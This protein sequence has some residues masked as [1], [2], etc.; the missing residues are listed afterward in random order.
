MKGGSII[1]NNLQIRKYFGEKENEPCP[2]TDELVASGYKQR[3]GGYISY[4]K[5]CGVDDKTIS[6]WWH[7]IRS[8][9]D[10][11]PL[12]APFSKSIQCGELL[13]YM[14]EITG[15]FSNKELNDLKNLI[16]TR[17]IN[18]RRNG[19]R[20]IQNTV[21]DRIKNIIDNCN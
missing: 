10:R 12:D 2:I 16:V 5:K 20:I 11:S 6:Q 4:A 8:W 7:L 15:A 1:M 18:D 3:S 21:W 19:N 17:Y 14:A 9:S 13:F